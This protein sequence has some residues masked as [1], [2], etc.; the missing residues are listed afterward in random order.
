VGLRVVAIVAVVAAL[1]GCGG[2]TDDFAA[3]RRIVDDRGRFAS[4]IDAGESFAE[5]GRLLL[6]DAERCSGACDDRFSAAAHA[7]VL[8]LRV[9]GCT[10][11]GRE[12]ARSAMARY[13]AAIAAGVRS[14]TPPDA[15][16]CPLP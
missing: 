6:A 15:P 5:A 7:N 13:L 16:S 1:A 11:P 8:A 2:G 4:G 9:L 10:A 12:D 14:P 3:A